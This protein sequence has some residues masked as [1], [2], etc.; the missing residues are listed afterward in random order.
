MQNE[1]I[2][3]G[4]QQIG[5]SSYRFFDGLPVRGLHAGL[6]FLVMFAYFFQQFNNWNFGFIAPA[7]AKSWGLKPTDIARIVF[8]YFLGMTAGAFVSGFISD[9]IGRRPAFLAA[10]IIFS[11]GSAVTTF[12]SNL[13]V[14]IIFRALTGFGI[15]SMM[16]VSNAYIAEMAPAESRGKW[17]NLAAAVGFCAAPV[18]ALVCRLVVP[19]G[20]EAWRYIFGLGALGFIPFVWG[21]FFLR[22]SPRWLVC[23]GRTKEAEGV[24]WSLT[25]AYTDLEGAAANARRGGVGEQIFGMFQGRYIMRTLVIFLLFVC[26]TP[27]SFLIVVWTAQLLN[28]QGFDPK[29]VLNAMVVISLGVP[30]GLFLNAW[31]TDRGGRKIPL[32]AAALLSAG[33]ALVFGKMTN[34]GALTACGFVLNACY[35]ALC[36]SLFTYAAESYPTRMRNTAV[37]IHQGLSRISVS[38]TQP[39]IPMIV[40]GYGFYAIFV[41]VAALFALPIIPLLLLGQ[42]TGGRSLE[43]L[44]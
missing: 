25:G 8:W 14:F 30:V 42:R 28:M 35:M 41:A 6:F 19:L 9:R 37:G 2:A 26:I 29:A 1:D 31:V 36:F 22:E 5:G 12:T 39:F 43:D 27:A 10:I 33:M 15:F 20:P 34:L 13:T 18:V 40:Q 11:V 7:I 23:G 32:A 4:E 17:Q 24:I 3:I 21:I 38:V 16:V 44:E